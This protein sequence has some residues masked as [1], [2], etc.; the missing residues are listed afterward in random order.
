MKIENAEIYRKCECP[1]ALGGTLP[2]HDH[3]IWD[4]RAKARTPSAEQMLQT[5]VGNKT[6][7][8]SRIINILS[9]G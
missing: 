9:G 7:V 4:G 8:V 1:E 2:K 5:L 3:G 6:P